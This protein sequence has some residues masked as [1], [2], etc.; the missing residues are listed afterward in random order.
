[1]ARDPEDQLSCDICHSQRRVSMLLWVPRNVT[2]RLG[3]KGGFGIRYVRCCRDN[4]T[5]VKKTME[6]PD[7]DRA[8]FGQR[9]NR[10]IVSGEGSP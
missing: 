1:M 9:A 4:M 8:G 7:V 2:R 5:C 6:L 3:L 10:D